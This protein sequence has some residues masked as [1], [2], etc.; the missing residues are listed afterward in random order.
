MADKD[1]DAEPKAP[2]PQ[3]VLP[4]AKPVGP[5]NREIRGGQ[6]FDDWMPGPP[7]KIPDLDE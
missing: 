4:P 1:D 2:Q 3:N 7:I 5:P 6:D